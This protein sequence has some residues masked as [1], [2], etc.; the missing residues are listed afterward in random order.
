MSIRI[1]LITI[2]ALIVPIVPAF[3]AVSKSPIVVTGMV[4]TEVEVKNAHGA[5]EKQRVP[6]S[7]AVPGTEVIYTTT[8]TNQGN[9]PVADIG[10][11]NPIPENTVYLAASAAGEHSAITYSIDGGK[12]FATA[13][14]LIVKTPE[15]RERL[16]LASE[17]THIRW[18]YRGELPAG[19]TGSASF[20]VVIK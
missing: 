1:L 18:A 8:F 13:D 16:A 14:K 12:T 4:E 10:I 6:V 5:I 3:A 2:L 7:K 20:R 17:Y 19:K 15:G 11:T 9:E